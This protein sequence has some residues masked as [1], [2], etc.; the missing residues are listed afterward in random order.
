MQDK[1]KFYL[2]IIMQSYSS[3]LIKVYNEFKGKYK[4]EL[5]EINSL[6]YNIWLQNG[7]GEEMFV[8]PDEFIWQLSEKY[9][10][11]KDAFIYPYIYYPSKGFPNR[12]RVNFLELSAN[13]HPFIGDLKAYLRYS[14]GSY[15]TELGEI[16]IKDKDK[17]K[18][19]LSQYSPYYFEYLHNIALKLNLIEPMPHIYVPV[20][21]TT[22]NASEFFSSENLFAQITD[23]AISIFCDKLCNVFYENPSKTNH[24]LLYPVIMNSRTVEELTDG[25]L[26]IFGY[27][28]FLNA[29]N[30]HGKIFNYRRVNFLNLNITEADEE[31]V[32]SMFYNITLSQWFFVPMSDY[33]KLISPCFDDLVFL[34]ADMY[35]YAANKPYLDY[36]ETGVLFM[37]LPRSYR[38]TPLSRFVFK[39]Y[40]EN[41]IDK[42]RNRLIMFD[43]CV[44]DL[45]LKYQPDISIKDLPVSKPTA[46]YY[47]FKVLND[48]SGKKAVR[49]LCE[50]DCVFLNEFFYHT[51]K[52]FYPR[53][54]VPPSHSFCVGDTPSPFSTY[55]SA[56][57][58]PNKSTFSTLLCEVVSEDAPNLLA[59]ALC[60]GKTKAKKY[61]FKYELI[62]ITERPVSSFLKCFGEED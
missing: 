39:N 23:A 50:R 21:K 59:T 57:A 10:D 58:K 14:N 55:Q 56:A 42:K 53:A 9:Y 19:K 35:Y 62:S 30:V 37:P 60:E 40:T 11:N 27:N 4:N 20:Y 33:L 32:L 13:T 3:Y 26:N 54:E 46:V 61:L 43:E 18:S 28:K 34:Y 16:I 41:L 1:H 17:L 49:F 48:S 38:L 7:V 6:I 29:I 15:Q 2:D 5:E 12:F 36:D 8:T 51:F 22:P 44:C 25:I 31:A 45:F 47:E 52:S 24:R